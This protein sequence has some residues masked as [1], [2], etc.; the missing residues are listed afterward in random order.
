[1]RGGSNRPLAALLLFAVIAAGCSAPLSAHRTTADRRQPVALASLASRA[2]YDHFEYALPHRACGPEAIALAPDRALWFTE[3]RGCRRI[4]RID[5]SG[6]IRE[7]GVGSLDMRTPRAIVLGR[8]RALW[9]AAGNRIG[10]IALDGTVRSYGLPFGGVE[11]TDLAAA[12]DGAI[13]FSGFVGPSGV[14]GKVGNGRATVTVQPPSRAWHIASGANGAIWYTQ[15]SPP[16][17]WRMSAGGAMTHVGL[18]AMPTGL[19]VAPNG[20]VWAT[21]R[22]PA[23][24]ID[25]RDYVVRIGPSGEPNIF[26]VRADAYEAEYVSRLTWIDAG[27]DSAW[28]GTG[29]LIG[30]ISSRGATV[31][32]SPRSPNAAPSMP[33]VEPNGD[34]WFAEEN[35]DEVGRIEFKP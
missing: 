32:Y 23:V 11:V 9:F 34:L 6:H 16:A 14:V 17:V 31:F 33:A 12:S 15:E 22:V 21:E 8:D 3:S 13:W 25:A 4:G 24:G 26:E 27:R 28:F 29:S 1:M 7:Y 18:D 35:V 19:A 2:T 10:R 20:V 30:K 5:L